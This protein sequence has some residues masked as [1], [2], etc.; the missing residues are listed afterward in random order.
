MPLATDTKLNSA[1]IPGN[2]YANVW[3]INLNLKD[4]DLKSKPVKF[5]LSFVIGWGATWMGCPLDGV[6]RDMVLR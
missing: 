6:L 5:K 4:I 1:D 2:L 3:I